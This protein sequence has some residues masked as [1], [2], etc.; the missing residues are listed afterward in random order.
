MRNILKDYKIYFKTVNKNVMLYYAIVL[1]A[2]ISGSAFSILFGIY[3]KN[4][5]FNE[6]IVGSILSLM[7][8]GSAL[9]AL[10]VSVFA[11]K[12]NKKN[13]I[14]GGL[15]VMLVMGLTM[16][17]VR[18]LP[19]IQICAFMFG[20][21]QASV[22]I[23][24]G[25]ILYENTQAHHRITAFSVAFVLQNL[26]FVISS[27]TLGHTSASL[28]AVVGPIAANVWVMNGATLFITLSM[29]LTWQFTGDTMTQKSNS[30]GFKETLLVTLKG[31]QTVLKGRAF[32]YV[33]QVGFIGFGAGLVV[34]FFSIYLKFMLSITDGT[35]GTIMAISQTG[36]I[37]GGLIVSPLAKRVG[38]V[39]TVLLC[40]L[41]SIPFLLSISFPQGIFIITLSFFFR[42]SLM[43]MASP[44]IS[45]L[46]MEI[47]E[48]ESRTHM[49]SVVAMVNHL[50]RAIGIFVGGYMMYNIS[51]NSPYYVTI[52]CYLI[53]T[54]IFYKLFKGTK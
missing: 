9:G 28:S 51:Y 37:L 26:A 3:L 20:V 34:P 49:S 1:V 7:T 19:I 41:F 25:P 13:T 48:D 18:I 5:S 39:K 50:F 35:V 11:S 46:A 42:S 27:Y 31:F 45:S 12:F 4:L 32:L 29:Y 14:L 43:N 44:V 15:F 54:S 6:S 21:G 17:N 8:L 30:V 24:Q 33:L 10:P 23:L 40:Q 38:R 36:T 47:V 52:I 2:A 53:G 16:I 22:M